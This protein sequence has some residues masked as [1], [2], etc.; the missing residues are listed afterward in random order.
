M[1]FVVTI[2]MIN[3]KVVIRTRS[4]RIFIH[5][6]PTHPRRERVFTTCTNIIGPPILLSRLRPSHII[7]C[8]R[9]CVLDTRPLEV[10]ITTFDKYLSRISS[11]TYCSNS[12]RSVSF[13]DQTDQIIFSDQWIGSLEMIPNV[14]GWERS[15]GVVRRYPKRP[16]YPSTGLRLVMNCVWPSIIWRECPAPCKFLLKKYSNPC[17][18]M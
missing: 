8:V 6:I 17:P 13:R 9:H 16:L 2:A 15:C 14:E 3:M 7:Y 5:V 1:P 4:V 11:H 12:K 18:L 10:K